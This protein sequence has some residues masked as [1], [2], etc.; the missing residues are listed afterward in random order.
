MTQVASKHRGAKQREPAVHK[1]QKFSFRC[2][3]ITCPNSNSPLFVFAYENGG[4]MREP[5]FLEKLTTIYSS[6]RAQEIPVRIYWEV[7]EDDGCKLITL[8]G[9]QEYT[10]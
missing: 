2:F 8:R 7:V 6:R 4:A 1:N 5:Q 9:V 3:S 10:S